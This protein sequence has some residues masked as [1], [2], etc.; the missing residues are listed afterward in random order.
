MLSGCR[1]LGDPKVLTCS[2]DS[3]CALWDAERGTQ[4]TVFAG[5]DGAVNA[6]APSADG[7]TFLS[8][9]CDAIVRLWDVRDGECHRSFLGHTA[10]INGVDWFPDQ[11]ALGAP[12]PRPA[13]HRLGWF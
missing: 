10:D 6:V 7:H 3:T 11:H 2:G 8:A 1:F 12:L 5:H 9:G 4:V 13:E